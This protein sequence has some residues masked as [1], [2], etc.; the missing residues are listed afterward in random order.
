MAQFQGTLKFKKTN[1]IKEEP[2]MGQN[3]KDYLNE[4]TNRRAFIKKTVVWSGGSLIAFSMF[5]QMNLE[6]QIT[7][8]D[9]PRL[10]TETIRYKGE[11]GQV[12]AY[13]AKPKGEGKFP[14]V[15]VIHENRGLQPHIKDVTRRMALEGF[16]ALAPDALSPQGGTPENPQEAGP[17]FQKMDY[18]ATTKD[19]TAAVAY[20]KTNPL[21]TGKVGCTGFCWGGAM[22][23]QV[24]V[25]SPGLDAA[26]PFY[27]S[28]PKEEEVPKIKAPM[29][30]HYA[31][32]DQRI[33]AGIPAFEAAL[34]KAD[35]DYQLFI[36][37]GTQHAFNNDSNPERY[38]KQA[39]DLAWKRTID[40]FK[41][42]LK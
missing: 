41:Q 1:Q 34:K 20:L 14:A 16:V 10:Y 6:G 7:K 33:N 19:F 28:A 9:D 25:H 21:T 40:F 42:R 36:Y 5:P 24:A 31:E 2:T 39:A 13:L 26:V 3:M 35:I 32:N 18:E 38:N 12:T 8:T 30:L 22:T 15:I 23:N 4:R 37:E 29:L 11:T 17:L 27:G